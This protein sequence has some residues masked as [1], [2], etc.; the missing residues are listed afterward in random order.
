MDIY[1]LKKKVYRNS[2]LP[3]IKIDF[4]D[5]ENNLSLFIPTLLRQKKKNI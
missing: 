1:K 2:S 3:I 4:Y 5:N